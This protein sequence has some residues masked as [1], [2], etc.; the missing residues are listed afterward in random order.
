MMSPVP[1]GAYKPSGKDG[2][3]LT[4]GAVVLGIDT[5]VL[6]ALNAAL[7]GVEALSQ[8]VIHIQG[9]ADQID[10]AK[11]DIGLARYRGISTTCTSIPLR[12][13]R[14]STLT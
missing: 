4:A 14:K 1:E 5:D 2:D 10:R 13:R 7:G 9:A 6:T 11:I 8:A 12:K 3:G